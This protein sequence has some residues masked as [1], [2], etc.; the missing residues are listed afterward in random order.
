MKQLSLAIILMLIISGCR[1]S[2][3]QGPTPTSTFLPIPPRLFATNTS[4]P[5][6]TFTP[7]PTNSPAQSPTPTF[8]PTPS[9]TAD[10]AA[11]VMAAQ[12]PELYASYPSPDGMWRMDIIL[13][14]C[15]KVQEGTDENAYEQL[16]LVDPAS[17]DGQVA[18]EQLQY[19]GGLGAY[20]FDGRYWSP[21]SRYFYYTDA[22]Q[23]FPDGCGYWVPP[24][25]RYDI[26]F[27]K[28][29]TLGSGSLSP[30]GSKVAAWNT[31]Q[32]A[33]IIWDVNDG[34]I[35]RYS[36]LNPVALVG[37]IA[38]SPDSQKLVYLQADSWCPLSGTSYLLLVDLA[39]FEQTLRID[40][41]NPTFG[42]V[43]WNTTQELRLIDENGKEWHYDLLSQELSLVP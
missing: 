30:D 2:T 43:E 19:C 39:N 17:E 40:Y 34:E 16:L 12:Q 21:N 35:V 5:K 28:N 37:P 11:L 23:G 25:S 8:I 38:W 10:L 14:D 9:P 1:P 15:I 6:V 22:R 18:A 27:A 41:E 26:A 3:T 13:Y 24:L 31:T 4:L 7:I 32:Q 29:E 36:P 20:G 42:S 33:M